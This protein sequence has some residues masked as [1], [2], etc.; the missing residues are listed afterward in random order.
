MELARDY[1]VG[2]SMCPQE[3]DTSGEAEPVSK[4]QVTVFHN[5]V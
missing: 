1:H 2:L 3:L 5:T 4:T